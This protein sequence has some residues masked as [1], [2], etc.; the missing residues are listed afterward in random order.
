MIPLQQTSPLSSTSSVDLERDSPTHNRFAP[1]SPTANDIPRP[2]ATIL[3]SPW[4][5]AR[6]QQLECYVRG[7]KQLYPSSRV[8]VLHSTSTASKPSLSYACEVLDL[9]QALDALVEEDATQKDAAPAHLL[10]VFGNAS[11]A[12]ACDFLRSYRM[13]TNRALGLRALVLDTAPCS[14]PYL[15]PS[16][17]MSGFMDALIS[18]LAHL[19]AYISSIFTATNTEILAHRVGTDL[20]D[21]DLVGEKVF[22]C[23]ML[24]SQ[25]LLFSWKGDQRREFEVKRDRV[26][27]LGR[28]NGDEERFW[29]GI[30]DAWERRS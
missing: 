22:R 19:V 17:S 24:K 11:A 6:P 14:F 12:T 15:L 21:A 7:Y 28:W 3:L 2:P 20:N 16:T 9:P 4:P 13:R 27:G 18:F 8:I 1:L 5:S 23:Y 10:H 25:G 30:E 29:L 26:D